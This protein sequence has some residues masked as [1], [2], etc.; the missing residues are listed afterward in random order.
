[1]VPVALS[2]IGTRLCPDTIALMGWFGP[3]GLASV[4]FT[5]LAFVRFDE[6]GQPIDTLVSVA[7]WTILLSV[8]AHG[9]SAKP[10]AAWYAR[11]LEAA[12]GTPVELVDMPELRQRRNIL[13]GHHR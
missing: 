1:M 11:R 4:V 5:L 8:V 6:A 9:V 10:L 2:M 12:Q 3:R 7:V 13:T